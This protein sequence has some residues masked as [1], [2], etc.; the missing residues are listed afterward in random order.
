MSK[1]LYQILISR[2]TNKVTSVTYL[3]TKFD[4]NNLDCTK[5][6]ILPRPTTYHT[7][8][9]SFQYKTLHKIL[10]LNIK[11][12]LFGTT[13]SPL[14]SYCYTNE[15]TPINLFCEYNSTKYLWLQ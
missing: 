12:N 9:L 14:C 1:E 13:K 6:L 11:L 3:E 4:A 2:R 7:Y 10:F 8:L 15:K 5:M